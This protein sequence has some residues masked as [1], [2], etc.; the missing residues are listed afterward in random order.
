MKIKFDRNRLID[1]LTS[2]MG[3]VSGRNTLP[4]I[5]GVLVETLEGGMVRL[6]TYD[7]KKGT[8]LLLEAEVVEEGSYILT[9]GRFLSM[10][11]LMPEG[12]I[13]LTVDEK[14]NATLEG[15]RATYSL[16]ALEGKD[17]PNMPMLLGDNGFEI[18]SSLLREM[19]GKVIHSIAQEESRMMLTG[20]Y[21][22][23]NESSFEIVSCDSYTLSV[24]KKMTEIK[25]VGSAG[26]RDFDFIIPEG[27]LESLLRIL[28]D[29][30]EEI[31]VYITRKHAIFK[32]VELTYFTRLIEENYIDYER[33]MPKEQ[34]VFITV[35]REQLLRGLERVNLVAD[36]KTASGRRHSYV[37]IN[38]DGRFLTLTSSSASGRI[39]EEVECE[40][41]GDEIE[42]GFN[43]RYL[44]SSL[45]A[46]EGETVFLTLKG[47]RSSMTI[48]PT[49]KDGDFSFFYMV[50]PVRMTDEV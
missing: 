37:K 4:T 22:K 9:A 1:K 43:C 49:E 14:C 21:F 48:E 29:G 19:I 13:T 34:T 32:T 46:A 42:I 16:F 28:P 35:N 2:A 5:E 17:F 25:L 26:Y 20:A 8:V 44:I 41:E 50:L 31:A 12:E 39:Y 45:R 3:T 40:R 47:A 38:T 23:I 36:E 6:S 24:C 30:D 7:M 27:G 33:I 18:K 10:V 15:G 11:R